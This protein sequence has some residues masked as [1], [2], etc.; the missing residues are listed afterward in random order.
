MASISQSPAAPG[1]I[2]EKPPGTVRSVKLR[3]DAGRGA[4]QAAVPSRTWHRFLVH[5]PHAGVPLGQLANSPVKLLAGTGLA[6]AKGGRKLANS[7][8]YPCD[9]RSPSDLP[10]PPSGTRSRGHCPPFSRPPAISILP[11]CGGTLSCQ[12]GASSKSA[13]PPASLIPWKCPA[14]PTG[15][16]PWTCKN[17][18]TARPEARQYGYCR[19]FLP[20]RGG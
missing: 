20:K 17:G 1:R 6:P 18:C 4:V 15:C 2:Q 7:P 16:D 14:P 5:P 19:F 9:F 8:W 10:G 11:R 13:P 3:R 12:V